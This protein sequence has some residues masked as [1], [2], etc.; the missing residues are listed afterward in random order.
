MNTQEKV[1]GGARKRSG[2]KPVFDK[3][4]PVT[5]YAKQSEISNV[6]GMDSMRGILY[7]TINE[8]NKVKAQ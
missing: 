1:W 6:G 7:N 5:I 2:R 8:L 4:I 3:K